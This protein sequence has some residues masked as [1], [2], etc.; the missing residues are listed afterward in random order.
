[1][2]WDESGIHVLLSGKGETEPKRSLERHHGLNIYTD[3][4][5]QRNTILTPPWQWQLRGGRCVGQTTA[6]PY[7]GTLQVALNNDNGEV[8]RH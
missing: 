8:K 2:L 5:Y 6:G 3:V 1:M 4:L 7:E